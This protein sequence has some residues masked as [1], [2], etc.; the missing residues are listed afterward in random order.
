VFGIDEACLSGSDVSEMGGKERLSEF[1]E[2]G[3]NL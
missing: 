2:K 1:E 3:D